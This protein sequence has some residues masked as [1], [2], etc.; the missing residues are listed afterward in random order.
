MKVDFPGLFEPN[1]CDVPSLGVVVREFLLALLEILEGFRRMRSVAIP[2]K[3]AFGEGDVESVAD[4]F[5]S[6][7][8]T[9]EELRVVRIGR[10]DLD[11]AEHL[12]A[13]AVL[14]LDED[15]QPV[16]H[17]LERSAHGIPRLEV[18]RGIGRYIGRPRAGALRR[19]E[20]VGEEVAITFFKPVVRLMAREVGECLDHD[21]R[22]FAALPG[23]VLG[24][25][26]R[27][28]ALGRC[29][30]RNGGGDDEQDD[31]GNEASHDDRV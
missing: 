6:A 27:P 31:E 11:D 18:R 3:I 17:S 1:P 25:Q 13:Y 4:L 26:P 30:R 19:S 8:R 21:D 20:Q 29:E 22:P 5:R 2:R 23:D 12:S 28:A 10:I 14:H 7:C 9:I 24:H 16:L 15:A